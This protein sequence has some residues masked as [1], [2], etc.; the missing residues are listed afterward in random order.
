ME[1]ARKKKEDKEDEESKRQLQKLWRHAKTMEKLAISAAI[2]TAV[3]FIVSIFS[4]FYANTATPNGRV[5]IFDAFTSLAV[6]VIIFVFLRSQYKEA[7][8]HYGFLVNLW[9]F[10]GKKKELEA[11]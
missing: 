5:I 6:G 9:G 10:E 8:A 7:L 11:K 1:E 3:V 4:V 2:V